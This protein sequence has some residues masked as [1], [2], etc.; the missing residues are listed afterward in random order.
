MTIDWDMV[1]KIDVEL[2]WVFVIVVELVYPL[3]SVNY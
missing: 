3:D 2:G 1:D